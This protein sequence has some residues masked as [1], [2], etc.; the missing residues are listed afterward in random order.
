MLLWISKILGNLFIHA[1]WTKFSGRAIYKCITDLWVKRFPITWQINY[2]NIIALNCHS[3]WSFKLAIRSKVHNEPAAM[4]F[5][6]S[7]ISN[8]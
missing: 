7:M 1:E 6:I 4:S 5:Y 2:R 3:L 8:R